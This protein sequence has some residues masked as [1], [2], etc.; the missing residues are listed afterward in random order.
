[1]N[2]LKH[3][4]RKA[5]G[6]NGVPEE[7]FIE[8]DKEAILIKK[9]MVKHIAITQTKVDKLNKYTN[10]KLNEISS[11]LKNISA[12]YIIQKGIKA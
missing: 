3:L 8:K 4:Y 11:D 9:T 2:Y 1:M 5:M 12:T 7:K 10:T 6:I